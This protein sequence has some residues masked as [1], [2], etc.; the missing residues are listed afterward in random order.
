MFR[1]QDPFACQESCTHPLF[2]GKAG[3]VGNDLDGKI[4]LFQQASG[5][6]EAAVVDFVK[7]G[8]SRSAANRRS[9]VRRLTPRASA[10]LGTV[11]G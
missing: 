2:A 4:G 1:R 6:A 7:D 11:M 3:Q 9:S 5:A 8:L 10:I